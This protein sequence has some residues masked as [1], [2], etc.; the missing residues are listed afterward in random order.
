MYHVFKDKGLLFQETTLSLSLKDGQQTT[1]TDFLSSASLVL[2]VKN[3]CWYFWDSPTNK[4]PFG[5]E[6][7]T[8]SIAEKM[9]SNTCQLREGEGG[10]A[11]TILEHHLLLHLLFTCNSDRV[12]PLIP[13]RKLAIHQ[14][15]HILMVPRWDAVG[16][17]GGGCNKW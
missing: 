6:W 2:D 1:G 17:R 16:T 12:K 7:D 15:S 11:T 8:P 3:A 4:Y 10:E 14:R 9:P 5:E 13:L